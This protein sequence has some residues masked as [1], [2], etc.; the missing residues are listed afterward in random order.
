M[1]KG[2]VLV[3]PQGIQRNITAFGQNLGDLAW[4]PYNDD[5]IDLALFDA[6]T[7]DFLATGSLDASRVHAFG[8]SQGGY[9]SFRLG[10]DRSTVL[11]SVVVGAASTPLGSQ[12][13]DTAAVAIPFAL[14]I[15]NE[16]AHRERCAQ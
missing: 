2:F 16:R 7:V 11:S 6:I 1:S 10:I 12:L 5:S 14:H 8:Y 15:G 4:D 9:M 13:I 3:V